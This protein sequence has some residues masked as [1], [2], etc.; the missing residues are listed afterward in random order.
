MS[1]DPQQTDNVA[2]TPNSQRA[3]NGLPPLPEAAKFPWQASGRLLDEDDKLITV[4]ARAVDRLRFCIGTHNAAGVLP[5]TE[6]LSAAYEATGTALLEQC[7]PANGLLSMVPPYG[8]KLRT[9][10]RTVLVRWTTG[11]ILVT[12]AEIAWSRGVIAHIPRV[13]QAIAEMRGA[14]SH[15]DDAREIVTETVIVQDPEVEARD[16]SH[17]CL[18]QDEWLL[19]DGVLRAISE[20]PNVHSLV[21][22]HLLGGGWTDPAVDI[23]RLKIRADR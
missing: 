6:K 8:Q 22:A 4:S 3:E 20:I 9:A 12:I 2:P 1:H 14:V 5:P 15:L 23:A 19:V 13:I 11:R 10:E 16:D 21:V 17:D 7:S 18:S